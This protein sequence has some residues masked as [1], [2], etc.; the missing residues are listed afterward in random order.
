M[1]MSIV[2]T[3]VALAAFLTA[4]A[5][6]VAVAGEKEDKA[7]TKAKEIVN[8][9]LEKL[10]AKTVKV[11]AISDEAVLK[12]FPDHRFLAVRF[13]QWPVA[14]APPKSLKS[15]N[16]FA[17][18]KEGKLSELTGFEDFQQ[19]IRDNLPAAL[20]DKTAKQVAKA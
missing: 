16:V 13:P 1:R 17:V 18:N 12:T 5:T 9:R 4:S 7:T 20:N 6:T 11:E 19:F 2:R 8:E 10:E 3:A 15:S 14:I